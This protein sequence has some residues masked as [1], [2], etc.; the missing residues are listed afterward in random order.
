[1]FFFFL[2]PERYFKVYVNRVRFL[3][4][5]LWPKREDISLKV[6][7]HDENGYATSS[8]FKKFKKFNL[9]SEKT[10]ESVPFARL[11]WNIRKTPKNFYGNIFGRRTNTFF[12]FYIYIFPGQKRKGGKHS[13]G[14]NPAIRGEYISSECVWFSADRLYAAAETLRATFPSNESI[15]HMSEKKNWKK[16]PITE[17]VG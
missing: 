8:K 10:T 16:K 3:V 4:R 9:F 14:Q 15:V 12:F 7:Y 6:F 17:N 2:E 11:G 1:M 13:S 5:W